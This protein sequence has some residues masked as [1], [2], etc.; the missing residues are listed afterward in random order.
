MPI[1]LRQSDRSM[2]DLG[3]DVRQAEFLAVFDLFESVGD[4]LQEK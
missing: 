4:L 2:P 3:I 1:A